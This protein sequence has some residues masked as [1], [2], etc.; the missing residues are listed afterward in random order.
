[1]HLKHLKH[2]V[3]VI[4]ETGRTIRA[5]GSIVVRYSNGSQRLVM[6]RGLAVSK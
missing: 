4:Y 3:K 6:P 2:P 5:D 1:M